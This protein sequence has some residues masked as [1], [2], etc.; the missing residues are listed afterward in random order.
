MAKKEKEE[1]EVLT[2]PVTKEE[3]ILRKI[4]AERKS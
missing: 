2:P 1:V 3:M 4:A